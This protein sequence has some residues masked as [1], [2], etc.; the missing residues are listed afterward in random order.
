[1]GRPL[2]CH[3]TN[4]VAL[5]PAKPLCTTPKCGVG[6]AEW[7]SSRPE[8]HGPAHDCTLL[9][10][11]N[12]RQICAGRNRSVADAQARAKGDCPLGKGQ[13]ICIKV[14]TDRYTQPA[15]PNSAPFTYRDVDTSSE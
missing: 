4:I 2:W 8:D 10:Q 6:A 11:A 9:R 12:L 5:A 3:N 15:I 14:R 13:H 7:A 1:Y